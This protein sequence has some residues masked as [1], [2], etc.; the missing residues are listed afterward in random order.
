MPDERLSFGLPVVD[1]YRL[2]K[3]YRDALVPGGVLCDASGRARQLPRYFYQVRSW[4]ES[5]QTDLSPHFGL[6]EFLQTDVRE[7]SAL[8]AF[9]R[10][11][12]CAVTLLAS[13]LER[14]REAVGTLV[15]IA[16]NGG[17][18]TP[19]HAV[20]RHASPHCWGTAVN[21]Y[22]I[23][24]TKLDTREAIERYGEVARQ[25]LPGVWVRPF[26]RTA[27]CTD[28]HLHLDF[29]FVVSVPHDAPGD[30]YNPKLFADP[31]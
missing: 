4:G 21:I 30:T 27:G 24:D 16:A 23:G 11:V 2:E 19:K 8:R 13:A 29:G 12:P 25:T 3:R 15:H 17:Y 14:F 6:W 5:R 7:A 9:P 10:F 18:R 22:R 31:M 1:G 20:T 28:D 26:G